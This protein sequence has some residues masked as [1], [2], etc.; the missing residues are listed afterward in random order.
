[1][2]VNESLGLGYI[3]HMRTASTPT[4]LALAERGFEPVGEPHGIPEDD[5]GLCWFGTIREPVEH[6]LSLRRLSD[7]E[8]P[9]STF[10]PEEVDRVI[11]EW[12][13]PRAG[14]IAMDCTPLRFECLEDDLS[15]LLGEP[16]TLHQAR[17]LWPH[18]LQAV[19]Q[20][21]AE[22]IREVMAL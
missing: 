14:F 18:D 4:R 10:T 8:S 19:P 11:E 7:W 1:M 6:M 9:E 15:A 5:M 12:G 13:H 22:H 21:T 3:A 16:I 20:G 17:P 2:Y